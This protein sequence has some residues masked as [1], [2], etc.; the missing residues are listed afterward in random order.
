MP[1]QEAYDAYLSTDGVFDPRVLDDLTDLGYGKSILEQPLESDAP[2]ALGPMRPPLQPWT[3]TFDSEYS[4][5]AVGPRQIDLGG[6]G[7]GL[8][9]RWSSEILKNASFD[10]FLIDA[11]GDLYVHG[12]PPGEIGW[13]IGIE[14]PLHPE[15]HIAI[16]E[17]SN[18]ACTT[19]S[20]RIRQWKIAGNTVHHLIDPATGRSGGTGLLSVTTVA[21]DPATAE[22]WSKYLFL[23]GADNVADA[24][25]SRDIAAL[26][27]FD[28]GHLQFSAH[29]D[30]ALLWTE[31]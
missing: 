7:K 30:D 26:W 8:A 1:F 23:Q 16:L 2:S 5:V 22:I 12:C 17:L 10:A 24:A 9:V 3:P 20:T 13:R 11:G 14:H 21:P 4:R 28:N 6:I 19:S 27:I 15:R 18:V 29:L 31:K 25:A